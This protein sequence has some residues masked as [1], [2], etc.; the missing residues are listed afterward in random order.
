MANRPEEFPIFTSLDPVVIQNMLA[1]IAKYLYN[2][3][4]IIK[5]DVGKISTS[6]DI[7]Y[8]IIER[9]EKR[10]IYFHIYYEGC[11]MGEL[12]EGALMCFWI[13]K[14]NPFY[15]IDVPN[16]I[17]NAKIALCLFMNMLHYHTKK[18]NIKLNITENICNDIYYGFRY[19]DL[20]KEAIMIVAESLIN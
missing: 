10:R 6:M 19:R 2:I 15:C 12:N 4:D 11:K 13:L 17:L 9:I 3:S 7:M 16:N 8:E 18:E 1:K 14:L 20:S 5:I